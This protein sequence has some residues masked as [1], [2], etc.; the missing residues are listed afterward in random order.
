MKREKRK[1][2]NKVGKTN[3]MNKGR[4]YFLI[5]PFLAVGR[6][7]INDGLKTQFLST[8]MLE[9]HFIISHERVNSINELV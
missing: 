7:L 1:K 9:Y 4:I 5:H 2:N 6:V 3:M 8:N